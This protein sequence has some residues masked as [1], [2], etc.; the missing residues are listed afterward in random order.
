MVQLPNGGESFSWEREEIVQRFR[1]VNQ[2]VRPTHQ[3]FR[4][5]RALVVHRN[6]QP[7][8]RS[9]LMTKRGFDPDFVLACWRCWR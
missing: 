6:L 7:F 2:L 1:L 8:V 9:P 4:L 3:R 5:D